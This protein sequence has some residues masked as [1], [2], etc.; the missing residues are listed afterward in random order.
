MNRIPTPRSI[1]LTRSTYSTRL[2]IWTLAPVLLFAFV[3]QPATSAA[4][5][6]S[7]KLKQDTTA[8]TVGAS[9]IVNSLSSTS[10]P[11]SG[12]FAPSAGKAV[13][14]VGPTAATGV[15]AAIPTAGKPSM[16]LS[17]I[18][19]AMG[20]VM[21]AMGGGG[22]GNGQ[23]QNNPGTA[24]TTTTMT[25]GYGNTT[26]TVTTAPVDDVPAP[27]SFGTTASNPATSS[28]PAADAPLPAN[29]ACSFPPTM[30]KTPVNE[31]FKVQGCLG[32][33]DA[34]SVEIVFAQPTTSVHHVFPAMAGKVIGLTKKAD[35]SAAG[36]EITIQHDS[37]PEKVA[38]TPC[39]SHYSTLPPTKAGPGEVSDTCNYKVQMG[40]MVNACDSIAE[41]P[42]DPS[43]DGGAKFTYGISSPNL[44]N[45]LKPNQYFP[46]W[47]ADPATS[48]YV[49]SMPETMAC[50]VANDNLQI[51]E[52]GDTP[53]GNAVPVPIFAPIE[54]GQQ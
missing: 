5:S 36:C 54:A 52:A 7:R 34:T 15:S 32:N 42:W 48:H 40:Q 45:Q 3:L 10:A 14:Q 24:T 16:D 49:G 4:R 26:T 22:G 39:F 51:P 50:S 11:P 8:T 6:P 28:A 38:S 17:A 47:A 35:D 41:I 31:A 18:L 23:A 33:A 13:M 27:A 46:L 9:D 43:A 1:R 53:T 44:E 2:T 12:S 21:S 37:C 29:Q 20:S 30:W 19:G 25:D